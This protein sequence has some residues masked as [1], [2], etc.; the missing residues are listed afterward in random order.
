MN[1]RHFF[2]ALLLFILTIATVPQVVAVTPHIAEKDDSFLAALLR[3]TGI[4]ATPSTV[5]GGDK[6]MEGDIWLVKIRA[7]EVSEPQKITRDGIYHTPL[8]I[9]KSQTILAMKGDKLVQLN[10]QG[11]EEKTLH[12]LTNN[13]MLLGFDKNDTNRVLM[14]QGFL[15]SVLTLV[16]GQ[17]T[18]LPYD[19]SKPKDREG[20]DQ[21]SSDFRDYGSAQVFIENKSE[22]DPQGYIEQSSTIYIKR[23]KHDIS[24]KCPSTCGQPALTK[25][26]RQLLFIGH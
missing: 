11:N 18:L 7:A 6:F 4:G 14:L 23:V 25:D 8:W 16:N 24:I 22:P 21:L 12:T 15:A 26:G 17:S 13:T 5:R 10:A 1:S 9:P 19:K 20:L 2:Q 3:F